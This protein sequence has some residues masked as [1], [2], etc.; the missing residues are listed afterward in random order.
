MYILILREKK[1]QIKHNS[2]GF[3][4]FVFQKMSK[5]K[6]SADVPSAHGAIERRCKACANGFC[7]QRPHQSLP[8]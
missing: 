7:H 5:E 3:N 1:S 4:N 6:R 2:N 8:L